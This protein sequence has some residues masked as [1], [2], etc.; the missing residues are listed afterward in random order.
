MS[1]LDQQL[2]ERL[3][4]RA[5]RPGRY[6]G[7]ERNAVVKEQ[8]FFR[9]AISYPDLYEVGMSNSGVA[10]IYDAV[11][12]IPGAAC[13]RVFAV[14]R[15]FESILREEG[16]P[17]YTLETFTPLCDLDCVGFN[18]SHELL[19]TNVLQI[20]DLGKIPLR[21]D[22]RRQGDPIVIAGGEMTSNPFPMAD[23]IDAFF[24]GDGEEGVVDI[25]RVLLAARE[26]GLSR[27]EALSLLGEVDGV[28]LPS[29]YC[30]DS[31]RVQGPLVRR[32]IFRGGISEPIAPVVPNVK[33]VQERAGITVARG[34]VGFCNF[35]HAGF[36]DLP[37][38]FCDP[39]EAADRLM[40]VLRNTG[41]RE[42]TLSALSISDYP[43]LVSLIDA[44]LP[45]LTERGI[46][47]SF[48]SLRVDADT[49]PLI[50]RISELRRASLTF[51]VESA[52]AAIRDRANK[53]LFTEDLF[54]IL[55]RARKLGWNIIK[56]YFMLGLPG[57]EE[58]DEA[59]DIASF[60][61]EARRAAGGMDINVTLSPF[62]PKPH[63]PFERERMMEREYFI[64]AVRRLRGMVPRSVSLKPHD[65]DAS[66][67]E[68]IIARGDD[69]LGGVI[70]KSY[71][72]GCRLDSWDEHFRFDIWHKNLS[73][74]IPGWHELLGRREGPLPWDRVITGFER[75]VDA[76]VNAPPLPSRTRRL[77]E[78]DSDAIAE[79]GRRF[80]VRYRVWGRM[81]L[82]LAKRGMMRFISHLEFI[83]VVKR[84]LRMAEVPLAMTQGF[85][86]R[87]RLSSSPP[88]P[89]GI[90]SEAEFIDMD[91][92][93]A[94][95]G[96]VAA[97]IN[98][99]LP[100]GIAVRDAR[101]FE[102]KESIAAVASVT[103]YHV[104]IPDAELREG[105]MRWLSEHAQVAPAGHR[106]EEEVPFHQAIHSFQV[107]EEGS[108]MIRLFSGPGAVRVDDVL[109]RGMGLPQVPADARV[110]KT[111]LYRNRED[112][113][114]MIR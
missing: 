55:R 104:F 66:L 34:C 109:C 71:L 28:L 61:A 14:D 81:R 46:S 63:T 24:I 78:P 21:R 59:G 91:L 10:I 74:I 102:A 17:L 106:H 88:I 7:G 33:I 31:G 95:A 103:E 60:L 68:G 99:R 23:F 108:V 92:Y 5:R 11:N 3:V 20:L 32:R 15:D 54:A 45:S 4:S 29:R 30:H 77:G 44:V 83:E 76:R 90:E 12:R 89:L 98:E 57:C 50:E 35:C 87:E 39:K 51:A 80:A 107:I 8:A 52:T 62:V 93:A 27:E 2:I 97:A 16:I 43:H 38:R 111:A 22:D 6:V 114:E 84:A 25:V 72:D 37:Y 82:R 19:C 41:Y 73:E 79:A 13:E 40:A 112:T 49:M 1:R 56:L 86:K 36:Y 48:P 75:L 69:R 42:V 96:D 9:M 105:F 94:P 65:I 110:I 101:I 67:L 85:N 70:L 18:L 113:I 53:R 100:S 47:V 26:R 58:C 64:E